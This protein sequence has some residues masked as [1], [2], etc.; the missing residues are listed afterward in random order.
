MHR[1]YKSSGTYTQIRT[2]NP[3]FSQPQWML[4][5][6]FQRP[7]VWNEEQQWEPHAKLRVGACGVYENFQCLCFLAV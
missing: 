5:P 2:P 7:H 3:I 1:R 4:I 6:L